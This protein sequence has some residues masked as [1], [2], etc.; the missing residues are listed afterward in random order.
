MEK[1]TSYIENL[2]KSISAD[3]NRMLALIFSVLSAICSILY[4]TT[5]RASGIHLVFVMAMLLASVANILYLIDT[6]AKNKYANDIVVCGVGIMI[7][8]L[9][10]KVFKVGTVF[11][12]VYFI[13]YLVYAITFLLLGLY[14]TRGETK[15]KVI[16]LLLLACAAWSFFEFFALSNAFIAGITWKIFRVS[17]AFI[18]ISY[19][20][21]LNVVAK[22]EVPLAE[23]IGS[24]KKQVPSCKICV[25]ILL[26]I[27]MVS[28]AIGFV[29]DMSKG[30]TTTVVTQKEVTVQKEESAKTKKSTVKSTVIPAESAPKEIEEIKI[31][32]TVETDSFSFK[33]N[34]VEL[35]RRV[36]PDNPPS[37][38]TYYQAEAEHTYIYINA[39]VTNK[40]K[41]A[42][43][44]DGIYSVTADYDGGYEYKGFN[45]AD[46]TDGDF[47][48]ANITSIE[49]LATLGVHCLIDCPQVVEDENK[50]L[51]ITISLNNGSKYKYI[52]K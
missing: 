40:E 52:I 24:Y 30:N 27:A 22:T 37:Y 36:E 16:K 43:E 23:K 20:C 49:P 32:D 14:C 12:V 13:G 38:Y 29:V 19:F 35:S 46:D 47:T 2:I 3:K 11:S 17:E 15:A 5:I 51:F 34:R 8:G 28:I 1:E 41:Y 39:S 18:A 6:E 4:V 50:P 26:V 25:S 10:L 42:M 48:Y 9:I 45:I 31:G 33:L 44:C 7:L 21:L